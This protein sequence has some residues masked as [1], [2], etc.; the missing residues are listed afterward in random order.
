LL[1]GEHLA[2]FIFSQILIPCVIYLFYQF[3][4]ELSLFSEFAIPNG[5][6]DKYEKRLQRLQKA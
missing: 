5:Y 6:K 2:D 1:R 4:K 3:M